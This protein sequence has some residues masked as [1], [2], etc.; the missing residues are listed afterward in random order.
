[1]HACGQY[2]RALEEQLERQSSYNFKSTTSEIVVRRHAE[3]GDDDRGDAVCAS[4]RPRWD[5]AT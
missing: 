4:R 1:M 3:G 2:R 5:V